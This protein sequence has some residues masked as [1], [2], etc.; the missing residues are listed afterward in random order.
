MASLY[1]ETNIE[2][3][4]QIG[5]DTTDINDPL[6]NLSVPALF[7]YIEAFFKAHRR[8]IDKFKM[9]N[10]I[11]KSKYYSNDQLNVFLPHEAVKVA[12]VACHNNL[13]VLVKAKSLQRTDLKR[14]LIATM[15]TM[16]NIIVIIF[17]ISYEEMMKV[18]KK[19]PMKENKEV[20]EPKTFVVIG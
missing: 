18:P 19:N 9:S 20:E 2:L 6:Y 13:K 15:T 5:E 8:E 1:Q 3:L 14:Q 10:E 17:T 4:R 11:A 7:H 16:R 12:A